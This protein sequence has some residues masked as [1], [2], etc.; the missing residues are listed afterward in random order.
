MNQEQAAHK[1]L[2]A[3]DGVG[4]IPALYAVFGKRVEVRI[5]FDS[6]A[7]ETHLDVVELSPR[8]IHS[9]KRAGVFTVGG[10]IDLVAEDR[11]LSIRCLGKKTQSEIKT[12]LLV[13]GYERLT[14]AEKLRFLCD[15]LRL[16]TE[17]PSS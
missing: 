10:V 13:F 17:G 6:S 1:L 14:A 8:A 5:P 15:V 9:L 4:L 12:R 7:C 2:Q 3:A 11:L 16:N